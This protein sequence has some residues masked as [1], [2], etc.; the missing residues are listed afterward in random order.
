MMKVQYKVFKKTM[1]QSYTIHCIT[2]F[3]V[4]SVKYT[5]KLWSITP[6]TPGFRAVPEFVS[7]SSP[8]P[9]YPF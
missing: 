8:L 4:F 2:L 9:R 3:I 6:N 7:K 5:S 1:F